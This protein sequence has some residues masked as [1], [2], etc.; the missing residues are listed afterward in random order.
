M[1]TRPPAEA[2]L[3]PS[4]ART[5]TLNSEIRGPAGDPATAGAGSTSA[6]SAR[7]AAAIGKRIA[8]TNTHSLRPMRRRA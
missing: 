3:A 2:A 8:I 6:A 1:V 5:A 4:G 7:P